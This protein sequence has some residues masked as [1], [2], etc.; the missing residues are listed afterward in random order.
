MEMRVCTKCQIKLIATPF[1]TV[2]LPERA[3]S[4]QW[5]SWVCAQQRGLINHCVLSLIAIEIKQ[6]EWI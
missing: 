6:S 4:Y 1:P 5:I 3:G 2:G